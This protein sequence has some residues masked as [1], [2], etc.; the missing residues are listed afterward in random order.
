MQVSKSTYLEK[1]RPV[2][3]ALIEALNKQF[4]CCSV[5]AQDTRAKSYRVSGNGISAAENRVFSGRGFVVRAAD[6]RGFAEYSFD[7]LSMDDI[8]AIAEKIE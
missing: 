8:P 1:M 4:T 6:D 5:L 7:R 3:R 2:M